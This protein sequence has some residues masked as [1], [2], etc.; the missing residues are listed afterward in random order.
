MGAI[1]GPWIAAAAMAVA[2]VVAGLAVGTWIGQPFYILVDRNL[3]MMSRMDFPAISSTV[4]PGRNWLHSVKSQ[5]LK[6]EKIISNLVFLLKFR[7]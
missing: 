6:D 7:R 3:L 4:L 2:A 5:D 1:T